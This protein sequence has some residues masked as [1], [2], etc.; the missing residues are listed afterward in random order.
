VDDNLALRVDA[1]DLFARV[2]IS[3]RRIAYSA[4]G[5]SNV[6]TASLL[7]NDLAPG[8]LNVI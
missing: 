8:N 1:V 2:E 4:E 6:I 7:G 5:K 3:G